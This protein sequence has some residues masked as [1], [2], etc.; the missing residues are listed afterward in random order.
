MV[1]MWPKPGMPRNTPAQPALDRNVQPRLSNARKPASP[2]GIHNWSH[3]EMTGNDGNSH[4]CLEVQLTPG[5]RTAIGEVSAFFIGLC[6]FS[7]DRC[8]SMIKESWFFSVNSFLWLPPLF[9]WHFRH[10][11]LYWHEIFLKKLEVN[12]AKQWGDTTASKGVISI[13]SLWLG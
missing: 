2:W 11:L 9:A 6:L 12:T 8:S 13:V 5:S 10:I 7:Y 1:T 3:L 4:P